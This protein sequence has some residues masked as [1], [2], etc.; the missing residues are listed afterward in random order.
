MS[1]QENYNAFFSPDTKV[2]EKEK[3]NSS[4]NEFKPSADSGKNGIYQAVVRFVP[5]YKDPQSGSI[6]EK[7]ISYLVDPVTEK[8]KYVDCPSS[9]GKPSILQDMYWKLKKSDNVLDQEKAKIF[10]RKHSFASI[11]QVIKDDNN[12][13]NEGK[14]LVW[15]Y[16]VKIYDK[17]MAELKPM[18][19]EK[20]DPFDVFNGKAFA[21]VVTKVSGYN[22]YDQT[23]FID[24][25]IPLMVPFGE[26]GKFRPITQNDDMAKVFEWVKEASPDLDKYNFKE[27]DQETYDYVNHVIQAVTG[28]SVNTQG[29]SKVQEKVEAQKEEPA[30]TSTD[31]KVD[32]IQIGDD[33]GNTSDIGDL[34]DLNLDLEPDK[35]GDGLGLDI[36]SD[37]D[38]IL[39]NS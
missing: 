9:V 23:K 15:R 19:G 21:V 2:P 29:Y 31:I 1:N 4:L 18:I 30:I 3:S 6:K 39:N 28:Q 32:D 11:I 24:K 34:P 10:S 36:S 25:R 5:W 27:W 16:G 14:L 33:S 20:H 26:G 38:D 7:W 17:I 13:E 22:N 8:G 35:G 12:P 37:L